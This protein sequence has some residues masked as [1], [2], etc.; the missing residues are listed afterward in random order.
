MELNVPQTIK[1]VALNTVVDK[2]NDDNL[3]LSKSIKK[4]SKKQKGNRNQS[5][6][7][8]RNGKVNNKSN[9]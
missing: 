7:V 1:I 2:L 6:S 5:Q 4:N 8:N 3:K 9:K